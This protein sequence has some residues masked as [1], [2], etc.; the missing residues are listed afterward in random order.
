[1]LPL[2]NNRLFLEISAISGYITRF[3]QIVDRR[4]RDFSNNVS[5]HHEEYI[6][7]AGVP[8]NSINW[9]PVSANKKVWG[10]LIYSFACLSFFE[11]ILAPIKSRYLNVAH[12]TEQV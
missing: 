12:S 11:Q 8:R 7:V 3:P 4:R 9:F 5:C 6:C 10:T 2:S 1:M